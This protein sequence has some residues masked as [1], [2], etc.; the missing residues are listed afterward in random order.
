MN[1][2]QT[3]L[4]V[5]KKKPTKQKLYFR[6]IFILVILLLISIAV[7]YGISKVITDLKAKK[8]KMEIIYL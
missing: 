5:S 7:N 2:K 4:K 3:K 6:F 1:K 8:E